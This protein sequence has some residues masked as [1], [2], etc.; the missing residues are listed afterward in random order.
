M[1]SQDSSRRGTDPVSTE[2]DSTDKD[3]HMYL[4][5]IFDK[6]TRAIQWLFGE[7]FVENGIFDKWYDW[8]SWTSTEQRKINLNLNLI[9]YF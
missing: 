1:S 8:N 3:P 2:P 9:L 4:Q 6:S 5:L 7:E